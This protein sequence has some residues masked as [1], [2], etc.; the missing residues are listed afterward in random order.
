MSLRLDD[1]LSQLE[2][3]LLDGHLAR[4]PDCATYAAEVTGVTDQLRSAPAQPLAQPIAV[5]R[6]RRMPVRLANVSAAA[7][8]LAVAAGV[9]AIVNGSQSH[10]SAPSLARV[11]AAGV[12]D[13]ERQLR[14]VR[15]A[16]LRA[17]VAMLQSNSSRTV[18]RHS[19]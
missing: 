14:D 16:Q 18:F 9:G 8:L 13:D 5:R 6:R 1:E 15:R 19:T 11:Q 3:A 10:V 12:V 2:G 7:A 4:C 17:E